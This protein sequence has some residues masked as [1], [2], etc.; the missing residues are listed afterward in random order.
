[1]RLVHFQSPPTS[2]AGRFVC[3]LQKASC[4]LE[5]KKTFPEAGKK[6]KS[7]RSHRCSRESLRAYYHTISPPKKRLRVKTSQLHK[8]PGIAMENVLTISGEFN[9]S[10]LC[11]SN[12]P[13]TQNVPLG[14]GSHPR[15]RSVHRGCGRGRVCGGPPGC[16]GGLGSSPAGA[17]QLHNFERCED[18]RYVCVRAL[19]H[20]HGCM[21]YAYASTC[22]RMLE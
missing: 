20:T 10:Y 6:A 12:T 4:R 21:G 11:V 18:K 22:V 5:G 15:D 8:L 19:V 3:F 16:P 13:K 2:E 7:S 17:Y 9:G 14:N 1:M